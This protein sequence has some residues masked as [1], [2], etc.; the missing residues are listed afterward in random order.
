M[1]ALVSQG[2]VS[3]NRDAADGSDEGQMASGVNV[4]VPGRAESSHENE[5]PPDDELDEYDL[6]NYDKEE[7]TGNKNV[8][9]R[10]TI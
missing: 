6:E 3:L 4:D 7:C 1:S 9:V 5:D 10:Y 2:C 8:N